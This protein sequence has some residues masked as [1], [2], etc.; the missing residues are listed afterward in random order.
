MFDLGFFV[1]MDSL[2]KEDNKNR[3]TEKEPPAGETEPHNIK[4][5]GENIIFPEMPRPR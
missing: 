1:Y 4:N 5:N 3:S 2:E